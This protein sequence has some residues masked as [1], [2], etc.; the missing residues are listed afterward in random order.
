MA[1]YLH[2]HSLGRNKR[3][4]DQYLIRDVLR[5]R[6]Q[7][8]G[9]IVNLCISNE[10]PLLPHFPLREYV[11]LEY[12]LPILLWPTWSGIFEGSLFSKSII[13]RQS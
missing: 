4:G 8:D 10:P 9:P 2:Y 3:A 7:W 1:R 5:T 11:S 6:M 13:R 12:I